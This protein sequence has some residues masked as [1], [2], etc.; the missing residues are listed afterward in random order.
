MKE[1]KIN[2]GFYGEKG[3]F[4]EEGALA[5]IGNFSLA[6]NHEKNLI[7]CGKDIAAVFSKVVNKEVDLGV[8][9]VENSSSGII[10]A[11]YDLLLNEKIY[12]VGEGI[13]RIEQHL[14]AN[15]GVTLDK[16]ENIYSH[17]AAI[18][19]CTKFLRAGNWEMHTG[20]DT[21]TAVR[22]VK[23]EKLTNAAAIAGKHAAKVYDMEIIKENIEDSTDNFTR[24][25]M[26][27]R[28][29]IEAK[30]ADKTSIAIELRNGLNSLSPY[31]ELFVK[32]GIELLSLQSRPCRSR[33]FEYVVYLDFY[34]MLND[35]HVKKILPE[36]VK[37]TGDFRYLGSYRK[38]KSPTME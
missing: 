38:A 6:K 8:V 3:S 34:G 24:F 7:P 18:Y 16:I 29:F 35:A 9:P 27:S 33:L 36:L 5:C 20:Q 1:K 15:K 31:L 4:S 14:I 11:T 13:N 10:N 32:N 30:D 21:A 2:V 26:I 12:V 17:K 28:D 19:Q 37:K 25:F 22:K 23:E